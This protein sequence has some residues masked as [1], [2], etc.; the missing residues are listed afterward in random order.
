MQATDEGREFLTYIESGR[1]FG[2]CV[3]NAPKMQRLLVAQGL[4]AILVG[5]HYPDIN[6]GCS[7]FYVLCRQ[8]DE[9]LL[10]DPTVNA[11]MKDGSLFM[12]TYGEA[13]A[14][15]NVFTSINWKTNWNLN[16][17]VIYKPSFE[18]DAERKKL[19]AGW[20]EFTAGMIF[21]DEIKHAPKQEPKPTLPLGEGT[22]TKA[23]LMRMFPKAHF[24]T[25]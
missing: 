2:K 6:S 9:V 16:N 4:D 11:E 1:N 7:N 15:M 20:D 22:I 14:T 5:A 24:N 3:S 17:I 10:V 13:Q 25:L 12:A 21:K 19:K 8:G 18:T 23:D